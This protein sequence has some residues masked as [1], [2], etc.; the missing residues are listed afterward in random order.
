MCHLDCQVDYWNRLG[1]SKPFAHPVNL[2]RFAQWVAP[3][4]RIVDY[5]CGYGRVLAVLHDHGYSDLIGVDPASAMVAEARRRFPVIH[6][7]LLATPPYL[8]L[9]SESVAAVLLFAVLTC[10]PSDD[11]QRAIVREIRR[12]LR[13]GGL[14]YI[15]DLWLQSDARN[16]DRYVRAEPRHGTYGV[17]DLPEGVTVRHHDRRWIEALTAEFEVVALD[18]VQV[19]TMNGHPAS[20]FQWFGVKRAH[21]RNPVV[22]GRLSGTGA[23]GPLV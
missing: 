18:A 12:V 19:E 23:D 13:P 10:V 21:W 8:D 15:S 7:E 6:C 3:G 11:G 17:F 20:G 1:P 4:D 14:L 5:G 22:D 16:T 9:P 2:E